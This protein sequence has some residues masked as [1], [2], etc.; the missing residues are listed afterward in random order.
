MIATKYVIG[1]DEA[2]RGPLAGPVAVGAVKISKD[3][4]QDMFKGVRD[5][6]KL[7]AFTREKWY[8]KLCTL[9]R[10]GILDFAVSFSTEKIIDERGI[11]PAILSALEDSLDSINA[12]P[13]KCKILLDGGLRAP[14]KFYDQKTITRGD[15]SIPLISLASV[16][17]KVSRDRLMVRLSKKYPNYG[18]D[19]HKGYGTLGHIRVLKKVGLCKLHRRTFCKN[20]LSVLR[21][22]PST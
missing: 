5:S 1:I 15:E 16:V 9:R 2:G 20:F 11:V 7:T 6:K 21:Q 13:S 10:E 17:A 18:F 3:F 22:I 12:R 4:D 19:V 14:E 8:R